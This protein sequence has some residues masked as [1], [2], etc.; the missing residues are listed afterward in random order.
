[1][2]HLNLK[3]P[4]DNTKEISRRLT[5][6]IGKEGCQYTFECHHINKTFEAREMKATTRKLSVNKRRC[7][8]MGFGAG[9]CFKIGRGRGNS[10]RDTKISYRGRK[11]I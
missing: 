2:V 6:V 8:K 1:M 11:I 5:V 3:Y 10:K 9:Q 7:L 4:L